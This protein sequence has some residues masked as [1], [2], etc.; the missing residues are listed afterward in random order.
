MCLA[1]HGA[2]ADGRQLRGGCAKSGKTVTL[3]VLPCLESSKTDDRVGDRVR[4][5]TRSGR[6]AAD[7]PISI[8]AGLDFTTSAI[9][10]ASSK[11]KYR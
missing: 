1:D 6:V 11:A 5:N 2:G 10:V 8:D 7:V 3:R 4:S 9:A